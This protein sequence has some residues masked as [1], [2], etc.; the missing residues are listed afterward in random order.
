MIT[1]RTEIA[2]A[3]GTSKTTVS[4]ARLAAFRIL[5]RV[6]EAGAFASVLL[7]E[8]ADKLQQSDR[9]LCHELVMGVLRRQLWLD[10]LIAH[11]AKRD[12]QRLDVPVRLALRL[13]LYQLRFLSRVPPSAAVNE[14]V[15]LVHWARVR[16]AES[17]VNAVLRRATREANYDPAAELSDPLERLAV[18]TS[19]PFWLLERWA[20]AF[21]FEETSA[22]AQANNEVAPMA[23]R[24]V[25]EVNEVNELADQSPI[26]DALR[27]AGAMLQPSE[28]TSRGWRITGAGSLLRELALDGRI[29][30]QDESSQLVA[31]VL[32]AR[33]GDRVL[34]VCAA[35]GSKTTHIATLTRAE[36]SPAKS[37]L[38]AGDL[39]AHRLRTIVS[40]AAAQ[41]LHNIHYVTFDALQAL[42]FPA[43]VFDRVLVDAPC[44]GTGTLRRNPEIRWRI[45]PGDIG[46]L[47]NRQI[48]ILLNAAQMVSVGGRLVY[49][50]CSVEPEE[51]E[52]VI[53]RFIEETSGFEPLVLSVNPSLLTG[54]GAARVWPHR[55]GADGFFIAA[56][57]RRH[58]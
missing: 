38:V 31:H 29:Y 35:P 20:K 40:T 16:S 1:K 32:A 12:P 25:N 41:H 14:S 34:D 45:S 39:H 42:P 6:E 24:L 15:K 43:A 21:G 52:Q 2:K 33:A 47:A 58:L 36:S 4:P 17:F 30:I 50:T 55:D 48:R 27:S 3:A 7:A 46:D 57:E 54:F 37:F 44:T 51:N 28:I 23:F 19:H 9:A 26:L 13:G 22:F 8:Q 11:Y 18:E 5:Q 10:R 53:S 56:F 49:S